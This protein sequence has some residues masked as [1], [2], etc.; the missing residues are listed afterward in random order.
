[1]DFRLTH[2]SDVLLDT[3]ERI[4]NLGYNHMFGLPAML[5]AH[6][7]GEGK[8]IYAGRTCEGE[9]TDDEAE[10]T[11]DDAL[12]IVRA[13]V[14]KFELDTSDITHFTD[15]AN[16]TE[17]TY[18]R[19]KESLLLFREPRNEE[20]ELVLSLTLA[21]S[22]ELANR[23]I[24]WVAS[25]A[26]KMPRQAHELPLLVAQ[27]GEYAL[28]I[29]YPPHSYIPE[30]GDV[31][32]WLKSLDCG[33]IALYGGMDAFKS[34]QE[35]DLLL[36]GKTGIQIMFSMGWDPLYRLT[37]EGKLKGIRKQGSSAYEGEHQPRDIIGNHCFEVG[38]LNSEKLYSD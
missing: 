17:Y 8:N 18:S 13:G 3:G 31:C 24:D 38:M 15:G 16:T 28:D 1:M 11:S 12:R 26:E 33:Q 14:T 20:R 32:T 10:E 34:L 9:L 25:C 30:R 4:L 35:A 22:E 2:H 27:L 37:N 7:M 29:E 36:P 21:K 23:Y 19:K 5:W 6:V